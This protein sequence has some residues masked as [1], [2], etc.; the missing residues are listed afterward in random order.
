MS[1]TDKPLYEQMTDAMK[2]IRRQ[3]ELLRAGPSLGD[4][5]DDRNVIADLEIEFKALKEGRSNLGP[6]DR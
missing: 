6:I 5:S 2:A 1:E 3:L 4:R